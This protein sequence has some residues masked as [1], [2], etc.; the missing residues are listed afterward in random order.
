MGGGSPK[1]KK[2]DK[3]IIREQT[4]AITKSERKVQSE[5]TKLDNNEKKALKEVQTLAKKGQHGPAKIM[6][7]QIA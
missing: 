2:T 1:E 3:E 4:R 7:K 5:I 6:A